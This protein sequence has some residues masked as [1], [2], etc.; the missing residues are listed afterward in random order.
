[1]GVMATRVLL[2]TLCCVVAYLAPVAVVQS[3]DYRPA[4]CGERR[5]YAG[6]PLRS[7]V[8]WTTPPE[9]T[10]RPFERSLALRLRNTFE[11]T[12]AAAHAAAMTVAVVQPGTGAW[13][14]T[15]APAQTPLLYWASAGKTLTAIVMWQLAEERQLSLDDPVKKWIRDVPNGS[16]ITLRDLLAHTSGLFSANE[17]I[18]A[19]KD[20]RFRSPMDALA[21]ARRH[22]A[23]FC[24]GEYWRYSNT[25]YDL[26][27]QVI[28]QVDGRT[29]DQAITA[30]VLDR[31]GTARMRALPAG[32]HADDVAPLISLQERPIDPSWPGA[33]GPIAGDA[34]DMVRVW[35]A[36]LEGRLL[37]AASVHQMF[38]TLYPMFG[39]G[40]FYGSGVMVFDVPDDR[41]PRLWLGHAG[42]TPGASAVVAY[43]PTER[44]YV[45]V[46]LTGDGPAVAVANAFFKTLLSQP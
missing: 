39:N 24:P 15:D 33:A 11:T 25:G 16:V 1:M 10:A 46:A 29:F 43:A 19:R 6:P 7:P 31:A 5:P 4:R 35:A 9:V 40:Q 36:L 14:E 23:M 45:A 41:S 8:E 27:G 32:R 26:L 20:L 44:A 12:K 18:A 13:A 38:A 30:R 21:I 34:I 37:P 22:G 42:G 3:Q 17:D 28:R 2:T